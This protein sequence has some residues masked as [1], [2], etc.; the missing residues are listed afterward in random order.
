MSSGLSIFED[1]ENF[2]TNM[3]ELAESYRSAKGGKKRSLLYD[4]NF[5]ASMAIISGYE[6][7]IFIDGKPVTGLVYQHGEKPRKMQ[8]FLEDI[9]EEDLNDFA[10]HYDEFAQTGHSAYFFRSNLTNI[11]IMLRCLYT[12]CFDSYLLSHHAEPDVLLSAHRIFMQHLPDIRTA[13][14]R[15][16]S[17]FSYKDVKRVYKVYLEYFRESL[18]G[19]TG[20]GEY[21]FLLDYGNISSL[22]ATIDDS[23]DKYVYLSCNLVNEYKFARFLM[24]KFMVS[25]IGMKPVHQGLVDTLLVIL[26]DLNFHGLKR[27][28]V[29]PA[30]MKAL[31]QFLLSLYNTGD[32]ELYQNG[33]KCMHE[34]QMEVLKDRPLTLATLVNALTKGTPRSTWQIMH[35]GMLYTD[36]EMYREQSRWQDPELALKFL[37]FAL[38]YKK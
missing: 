29:S 12:R 26:H 16:Y 14:L 30:D 34:L 18:Y 13:L 32:K 10:M 4:M 36:V 11:S 31:R 8:F 37:E 33:A 7:P 28:S 15:A 6:K 5:L 19:K 22:L 3:S 1:I 27:R 38:S 24:T 23:N 2:E 21:D 25:H 9:F 35:D 20:K 17:T